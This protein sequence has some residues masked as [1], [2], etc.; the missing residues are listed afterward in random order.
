MTAVLTR[1]ETTSAPAA[2]T[3]RKPNPAMRQ[4][5]GVLCLL[6]LLVVGFFV[7][8]F[9]LSSVQANRTQGTLYKTFRDQLSR[10]IAPV[11]PTD[12]GDPVA[13]LSIPA[14]DVV[15]SIVVE[16]TSA[17]ALTR[18]PGHRMDTPLPGQTGVAVIY[19]RRVTFGAPFADLT[20][21]RAGDRI[22]TTT[23]HGT[24]NYRVN[25]VGT[26]ENPVQDS[27]PNRLVLTTGDSARWPDSTI[28]VSARLTNEMVMPTAGV[29]PVIPKDHQGLARSTEPLLPLALWSMALLGTVTVGT[30][31][32]QRWARWPAYLSIGPVVL[33][34]LWNVY[35]NAAQLMPNLY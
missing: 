8:V 35:E 33:A 32:S 22:T 21:L 5:G 28:A 30:V 19:G 25:S 27:W 7:Y 11:V 15:D 34:I 12:Q 3:K 6:M 9:A 29:Y 2:A 17:S 18:G 20:R 26:A 13:I 10:G 24:F 4:V 14:I 1:P 31:A 23:G 16:G